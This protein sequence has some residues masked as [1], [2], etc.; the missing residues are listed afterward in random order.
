[1]GELRKDYILDKWTI[2]APKRGKRPHEFRVESVPAASGVDLFAPGNEGLTPPEIGR[3]PDGKGG[4]KMRWFANKFA[5]LQPE[6]HRN[7]RTDNKYFTWANNYGYH[8]VIVE[9]PD[10]RQLWDLSIDEITILLGVWRDRINDLLAKPGIQ[11][12]EV[13]KNSGPQGGTSLLH[14]H[15]QVTALSVLPPRVME[16]LAAVRRFLK[17]PY[18]EII[19]I[20]MTGPRKAFDN[21][22]AVAF[23]P[24]ASRF[25]FETWIFPKQFARTLDDVGDL[26][27]LAEALHTILVKLKFLNCSYNIELHYSPSCEDLHLHF[28]VQPRIA[29]WAGFELGSG[30]I[31]NSVP[32]EDA[33]AFYRGEA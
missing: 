32:P 33:A 31:I 9:T 5:A 29:I 7:P 16:E 11:Y 27:P 17:N 20:E 4:W 25:N 30:I 28:E 6:G 10:D 24:Y 3:V 26:R 19:G 23:C 12:V 15:T 18:E 13:F 2:I 1:M 22:K 14:S 8:E 21:G